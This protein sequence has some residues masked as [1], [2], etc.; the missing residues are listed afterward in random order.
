M[1]KSISTPRARAELNEDLLL[2][3]TGG[4]SRKTIMGAKKKMCPICNTTYAGSETHCSVPTCYS[5]QLVT[6]EE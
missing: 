2:D 1:K 5:A 4:G 3:V 6:Y